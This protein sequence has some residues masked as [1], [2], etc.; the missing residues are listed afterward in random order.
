MKLFNRI[1]TL[2][3][4]RATVDSFQR[5]SVT[6]SITIRDMRMQF[7]IVK[8]T[9][10][11]PNTADV[12]ITNLSERTRADLCRKPM[13]IDLAAGHDGAAHHLFT[14]DLRYGLSEYRGTEWETKLQ[15][16]DGDRA[17]RLAR[18]NR[19]Y[20]SGT[21]VLTALRDVATSMGLVLPRNV[22]VSRDLRA[23]FSAGVVLSG[24][25][26]DELTRL[27]APYDYHWSSQNNQLQILRNN[28]VRED[29]AHVISEDTGM[30]DVPQWSTPTKAGKSP[31]LQ[32]RSL[33][34]P[35]LIPGGKIHVT[36]RVAN[37]LFRV[38]KLT[39]TGD[40]EGEDWTTEIEAKS[41]Y[42]Y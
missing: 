27:L 36:S 14:G 30:I 12:V 16:G 40:T 13:R 9:G 8:S 32:I 4:R 26:R 42:E 23:Q 41:L 10:S 38:E 19:S 34:Y 22:E 1:M 31:K 37:G 15:L 28:E 39:H 35:A 7:S 21:S 18:V 3:A 29:T 6:D 24:N 11:D 2:T 5:V 17:Y 20:K 25:A 33:L